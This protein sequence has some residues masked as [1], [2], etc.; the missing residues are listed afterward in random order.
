MNRYCSVIFNVYRK[1]D[2]KTGVM[3][4]VFHRSGNTP[5]ASKLLKINDRFLF[6]VIHIYFENIQIKN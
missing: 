2:L 5:D 1:P 4:D 6:F 3:Y